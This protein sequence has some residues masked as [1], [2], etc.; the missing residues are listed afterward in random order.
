MSSIRN[1]CSNA[2]KAVE[3]LSRLEVV[4]MQEGN[5]RKRKQEREAECKQKRVDT[6]Q[7]DRECTAFNS[8]G[9]KWIRIVFDGEEGEDR[10]HHRHGSR[11]TLS[12]ILL[13]AMRPSA[14]SNKKLRCQ[15]QWS[16]EESTCR[17][18]AVRKPA[19]ILA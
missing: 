4:G 18:W 6:R 14:I 19:F 5:A 11:K 12:S 15:L 3:K 13:S 7:T 10:R 17:F 8:K 1:V 9:N 2:G 16:L